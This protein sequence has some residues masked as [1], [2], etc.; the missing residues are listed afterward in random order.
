MELII[1]SKW[2]RL[3]TLSIAYRLRNIDTLNHKCG[4]GHLLSFPLFPS[5]NVTMLIFIT[6]TGLK[7]KLWTQQCGR[8][9]STCYTCETVNDQ[10]CPAV[11]GEALQGIVT[12]HE[13]T[14]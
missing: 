13:A 1:V 5:I 7:E 8:G 9:V 11:I 4:N 3:G 6:K 12:K 2:V 14:S 10:V